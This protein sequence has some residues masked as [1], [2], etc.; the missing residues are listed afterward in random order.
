MSDD[1]NDYKL[2]I[3]TDSELSVNLITGV[4]KTKLPHLLKIIDKICDL[5]LILHFDIEW[6]KAHNNHKWNTYAD[7]LANNAVKSN[8]HQ[9]SANS[10]SNNVNPND[11]GKIYLQCP[12]K[13]KEQ[14]KS[15]G[16]RWDAG[17]KAWWV[18]DSE[19]N[20]NTFVK[21]IQ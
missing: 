9:P 4:K 6:V 5:K 17:M 13:E 1:M 3:Y 18:Q 2:K 16:A 10:N 8:T 14:V 15:L 20:R 12:F 19:E 11:N 21:W 7:T